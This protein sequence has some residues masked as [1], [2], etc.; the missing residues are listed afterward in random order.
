M[1]GDEVIDGMVAAGP[2]AI[3]VPTPV[4]APGV[5]RSATD[6]PPAGTKLRVRSG[7]PLSRLVSSAK[8]ATG[9]SSGTSTSATSDVAS[10]ATTEA[11]SD[12]PPGPTMVM[13]WAP[14]RR[15]AVVATRPPSATATPTMVTVPCDVVACS[16]TT[17]CPAA[18]ATA[19]TAFCGP[20]RVVS[21]PVA[22][23]SWPVLSRGCSDAGERSTMT[24]ATAAMTAPT[25]TRTMTALR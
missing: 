2:L 4:T 19:G 10:V 18:S 9:R 12:L 13:R 16:S 23:V 11:G 24:Q 8:G 7:V 17:E 15:S 21:D 20:A 1:A 3:A 25:P 22:A 14:D 6:V 5:Q